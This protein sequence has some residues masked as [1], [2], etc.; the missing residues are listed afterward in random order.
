[1]ASLVSAGEELEETIVG[2]K[3][4]AQCPPS[5]AREADL[6]VSAALSQDPIQDAIGNTP[7]IDHISSD[8]PPQVTTNK[9]PLQGN[10][11]IETPTAE[12]NVVVT[13]DSEASAGKDLGMF[14]E[15]AVKFALIWNCCSISHEKPFNEQPC[16]MHYPVKFH[17]FL[18]KLFS[19]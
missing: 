10:L 6:E 11:I 7:A 12:D 13:S 2:P 3:C 19:S 1:M 17:H 15:P 18:F 9:T 5:L 14:Y 4:P 16:R 8:L